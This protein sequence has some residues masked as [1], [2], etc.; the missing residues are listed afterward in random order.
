MMRCGWDRVERRGF[1]ELAG[2]VGR[3]FELGLGILIF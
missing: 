1:W 3:M 2:V